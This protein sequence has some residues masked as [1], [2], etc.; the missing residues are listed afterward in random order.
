VLSEVRSAE[1]GTYH[2]P[3]EPQSL[4]TDT[5]EP[6]WPGVDAKAALAA[7]VSNKNVQEATSLNEESLSQWL[8]VAWSARSALKECKWRIYFSEE[9]SYTLQR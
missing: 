8:S 2:A 4:S 6:I 9:D 5:S 7:I 1:L 3:L